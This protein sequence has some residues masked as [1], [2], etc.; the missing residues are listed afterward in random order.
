M[1][2]LRDKGGF[3]SPVI[4]LVPRNGGQAVLKDFRSRN[5]LTRAVLGPILVRREFAILR[6]L[7]GIPGVPKAYGIVDGRAI[8][9][10]YVP[11]RTLGKFRPGELPDAF[12]RDL[13]ETLDS[14]HRRGVVHLDLRQKKNILV[15]DRD[16][17]PHIIDFANA[18]R[19]DG[20]LGI[21][22]GGLKAVDRGGLLKFKARFFP[23]LL[24]D[25]DRAALKRQASLRKFWPFS[26]HT[27][28]ERDIV[29]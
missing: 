21:L 2:V 22:G 16:G 23:H 4:R 3:L 8:L 9:L 28:R 26:P 18:A 12:Y 10:E 15:A 7:D 13:E 29:W 20:A 6:R 5:P 11:G 1:T 24:T 25:R 19:V 27:V 17:R 14:I